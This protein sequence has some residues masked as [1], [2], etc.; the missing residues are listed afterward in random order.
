VI[1][2]V[3]NTGWDQNTMETAI[4]PMRRTLTVARGV[5][6]LNCL[7]LGYRQELTMSKEIIT[8]KAS[9]AAENKGLRTGA[10]LK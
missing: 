10:V 3:S 9:Q 5:E 4:R 1:A 6:T 2:I 8:T 7:K